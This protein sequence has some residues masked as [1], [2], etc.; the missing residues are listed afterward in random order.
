MIKPCMS[1]LP[2]APLKGTSQVEL[3]D[4]HEVIDVQV[5]TENQEERV[6]DVQLGSTETQRLDAT[7]RSIAKDRLRRVDV[8]PPER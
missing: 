8:R 3:Q 6:E 4:D 7:K 5:L 1:V 2:G